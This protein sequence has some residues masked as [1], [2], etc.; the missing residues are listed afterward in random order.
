MA[1]SEH[2]WQR[3]EARVTFAGRK[4]RPYLG[5]PGLC[6][7]PSALAACTPGSG[8]QHRT[9]R[10]RAAR[11]ASGRGVAHVSLEP[12]ARTDR[13]VCVK[14]AAGGRLRGRGRQRR[15]KCGCGRRHLVPWNSKRLGRRA[16][17]PCPHAV[18]T[19]L[20]HAP[21]SCRLCPAFWGGSGLS[22]SQGARPQLH[23]PQRNRQR[24]PAMLRPAVVALR[25]P[26]VPTRARARR[27][28][29]STGSVAQ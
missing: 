18:I 9:P 10:A 15:H 26:S 19:S 7:Q 22:C 3:E 25:N 20:R 2:G 21:P 29:R 17:Q 12:T 13:C 27:K 28:V 14:C 24:L 11:I 4:E 6:T 8:R 1:G 23:A 16:A 5:S